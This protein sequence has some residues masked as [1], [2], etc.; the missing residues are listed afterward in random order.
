MDHDEYDDIE[1]SNDMQAALEREEAKAA[2][3]KAKAEPADD[4]LDDDDDFDL[5]G[6]DEDDFDDDDDS[7]GE[8]EDDDEDADEDADEDEAAADDRADAGKKP[9]ADDKPKSK[10]A[11]R[12]ED[13]AAKRREAEAAQFAAEMRAIELEQRLEAIEARQASEKPKVAAQ[14]PRKEDFEYGEVDPAYIDATVEYRMAEKTAEF[15]NSRNTAVEEERAAAKK[16]HY[17]KRLAAVAKEGKEKFGEK[18]D[19]IVNNTNF[20]G[21]VALEIL[22][23]THGVDI[24]YYLAKNIGKLRELTMMSAKD[25]TKAFGRLEERFSV[26]ASTGKKRSTA[27]TTPGKKPGRKPTGA[28]SRYGPDSQD[29]FDKAFFA[30]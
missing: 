12:I 19:K 1:L 29:A 9:R 18:Y 10:A 30:R 22:D 24:S 7:T 23:S 14:P 25:R 5:L 21:E 6:E 16:A 13:L 4:D 8:D 27:P 2:K 20:P 15:E 17:Q 28:E 26:R 3:A 11:K